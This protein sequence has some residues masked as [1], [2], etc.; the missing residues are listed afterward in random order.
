MKMGG[1]RWVL[2]IVCLA[3]ATGALACSD[4]GADPE[5]VVDA[6]DSDVE[7]EEVGVVRGRLVN[8]EG[9]P[10][11]NLIVLCCDASICYAGASDDDG[12]YEFEEITAGGWKMQVTDTEDIYVDMVFYQAVVAPGVNS[13][14]GDIVLTRRTEPTVLWPADVGGDATL[15]GGAL[16]L[17]S[18]PGS[19]KY[20]SGLAE[21]AILA[22]R[23][24]LDVLPPFDHEPW[25]DAPGAL[26]FFLDPIHVKASSPVGL[27]ALAEGATPG[28]SVTIWSVEPNSGVLQNAGLGVV[29]EDG[30]IV[31]DA[32]ASLTQLTALILVPVPD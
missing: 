1:W 28:A 26:A 8:L 10:L 20:P 3:A 7:E 22:Q 14:P 25:K 17:T 24:P 16:V 6:G 11:G 19:L 18:A 2:T 31:S 27:R 13:P 9:A 21:E 29:D 5:G 4:E 30:W 32:E 12:V 23:V 15:A